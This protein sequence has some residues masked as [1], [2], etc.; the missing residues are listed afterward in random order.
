LAEDR[1]TKEGIVKGAFL[2]NAI[3][4]LFLVIQIVFLK[5]FKIPVK[6]F[7]FFFFKIHVD[8]PKKHSNILRIKHYQ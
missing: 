7:I 5:Y 6:V 3:N 2:N 1:R 4:H 8:R